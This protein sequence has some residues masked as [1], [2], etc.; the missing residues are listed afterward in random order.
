MHPSL[1]NIL[2][3]IA[4]LVAGGSVNMAIVYLGGFVLPPP[5]GVDLGDPASIDAN[6]A[7]YSVPQLLA[8]FAAHAGGT[9]AGAWLAARLAASRPLLGA[10]VVGAFFLLGGIM[11]VRAVPSTPAWFAALDLGFA[12]GP[13]AIAGWWLAERPGGAGAARP[14]RTG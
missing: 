11:M 8:P 2:G 7:A 12:Y 6:M 14:G 10:C 9:L 4:G 3:T 1:R 5:A 13:M